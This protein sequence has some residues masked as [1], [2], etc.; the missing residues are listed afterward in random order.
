M[1]LRS[2]SCS[3][4]VS[5]EDLCLLAVLHSQQLFLFL[6]LFPPFFLAVTCLGH[7]VAS[8]K[9]WW[10]VSASLVPLSLLAAAQKGPTKLDQVS[11]PAPNLQIQHFQC[12]VRRS[13]LIKTLSTGTNIKSSENIS[14]VLVPVYFQ[15]GYISVWIFSDL[16][17]DKWSI[18]KMKVVFRKMMAY[19]SSSPK[20]TSTRHWRL[21]NKKTFSNEETLHSSH[22]LFHESRI[23]WKIFEQHLKSW[24]LPISPLG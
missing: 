2:Q 9:L 4:R 14:T 6:S 10:P 13:V 1:H 17:Q 21:A 11:A 23:R 12:T 24:G 22:N 18:R 20:C 8:A 16:N 5:H 7:F 3:L 19:I 15:Y